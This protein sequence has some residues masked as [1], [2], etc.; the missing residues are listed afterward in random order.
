MKR[1]EERIWIGKAK[2][3]SR[4][5]RVFVDRRRRLQLPVRPTVESSNK[6]RQV[7]LRRLAWSVFASSNAVRTTRYEVSPRRGDAHTFGT[8]IESTMCTIPTSKPCSRVIFG[9]SSMATCPGTISP[10]TEWWSLS[11]RSDSQ[12]VYKGVSWTGR[13]SLRRLNWKYS[14]YE[15]R[16]IR[17]CIR[18]RSNVVLA[19]V[20]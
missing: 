10:G 20:S 6:C 19:A 5:L 3:C 9:H 4:K 15:L 14:I 16:R 17:R 18:V 12:E 7:Y 11:P 8:Y 2:N 1:R 13:W